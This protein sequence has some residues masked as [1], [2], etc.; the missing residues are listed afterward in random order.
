MIFKVKVTVL[1]FDLEPSPVDYSLYY[2]GKSVPDPKTVVGSEWKTTSQ[3]AIELRNM[4][5]HG[6]I[7]RHLFQDADCLLDTALQ[8]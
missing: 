8:Y 5:D 7:Y 6:V 4:K 3:Y 1:P 2:R